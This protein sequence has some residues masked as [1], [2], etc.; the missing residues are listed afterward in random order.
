MALINL[1]IINFI[2]AKFTISKII[3]ILQTLNHKQFY[4][5]LLIDKHHNKL[6]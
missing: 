1:Y 3:N 5:N 2:I 4:Y 6:H